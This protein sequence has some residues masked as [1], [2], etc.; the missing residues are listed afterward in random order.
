MAQAA[1][2]V[3][4]VV[5]A[6][7]P[8]VGRLIA[9]ELRSAASIRIARSVS[10]LVAELVDDPAP[11]RVLVIDLDAIDTLQLVELHW[12]RHLGWL[13]AI[14]GVGTVSGSLAQSLRL[15][16]TVPAAHVHAQ[17]ADAIA[18]LAELRRS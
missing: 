11:P 12:L 9:A 13:G 8:P 6:P 18:G 16:R 5:Y 10:Q 2:E 15:D 4:V 1:A 17:L 7:N 3:V 14:V